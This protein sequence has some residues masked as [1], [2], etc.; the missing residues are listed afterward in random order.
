MVRYKK[1][2][3]FM[4]N[5]VSQ[6]EYNPYVTPWGGTFGSFAMPPIPQQMQN[7]GQDIADRDSL[8][9]A[10]KGGAMF[11][12]PLQTYPLWRHPIATKEAFKQTWGALSGLSESTIRELS[13]MQAAELWNTPFAASK[14]AHL[15]KKMGDVKKGG[16]VLR[17]AADSGKIATTLE[18]T[19]GKNYISAVTSGKTVEAAKLKA[20]MEE[21]AKSSKKNFW[22]WLPWSNTPKAQSLA[23]VTTKATEAG[24]KAEQAA[25]EA[26]AA[27]EAASKAAATAEAAKTGAEAAATAAKAGE[28]AA[29]AGAETAAA[30]TGAVASTA[31]KTGKGIFGWVKDKLITGGAKGMF[32]FDFAIQAITDIY[33]A[34]RDGGTWEGIKQIGRSAVHSLGTT[35]G[36]ILGEQLGA[37]GG[38]AIGKVIGGAIGTFFGGPV[39]TAAGA[40]LGAAIGGFAGK[41][42]AG[43][44][45]SWFGGRVAKSVVGKSFSERKE[46]A[47]KMAA[48]N[49]FGGGIPSFAGANA[50]SPFAAQPSAGAFSPLNG[51]SG[52][53]SNPLFAYNSNINPYLTAGRTI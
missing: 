33:P 41:M 21:T 11:M 38:T 14:Q 26:K 18:E 52:G 48:N 10:I 37:I 42:V 5:G 50:A 40:A 47:E 44:T 23:E 51:G 2:S 3:V 16:E 43:L 7:F 20:V 45:G 24:K 22:H 53:M 31:A 46:D 34:F 17:S 8:G 6:V 39:G 15:L 36:W 30:A 12:I 25:I 35:V 28:T 1:V 49:P 19:L 27:A 13:G 4:T 32:I 29:K 9:S